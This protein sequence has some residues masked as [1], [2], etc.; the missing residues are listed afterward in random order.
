MVMENSVA[1]ASARTRIGGPRK[2]MIN[3]DRALPLSHQAQ[4]LDLAQLAV[5][6]TRPICAADLELMRVIETPHGPPVRQ[7]AGAARSA[8]QRL[9]PRALPRRP[10]D[11]SNGH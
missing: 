3:R 8:E 1:R 10:A 7:R 2:A 6:P 11:G 4:L 9:S 5:L